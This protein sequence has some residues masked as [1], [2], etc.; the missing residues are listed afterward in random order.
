MKSSYKNFSVS[1]ISRTSSRPFLTNRFGTHLSQF[2]KTRTET[3]TCQKIEYRESYSRATNV[4]TRCPSPYPI[5]HP[6]VQSSDFQDVPLIIE[7]ARKRLKVMR[8][9]S[10]P[11][12]LNDFKGKYVPQHNA[13]RSLCL[14]L[15]RDRMSRESSISK[16]V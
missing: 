15:P 14:N 16:K 3:R 9:R 4:T 2:S 13:L 11:R 12:I 6:S 7:P 1:S 10:A 8:V 5:S